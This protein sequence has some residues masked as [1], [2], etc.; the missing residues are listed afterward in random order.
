MEHN[1]RMLTERIRLTAGAEP[2]L[3]TPVSG[4]LSTAEKYKVRINGTEWLAKFTKGTPLRV[5]WYQELMHRASGQMVNPKAFRLFE[6][7]TLCLLTRWIDGEGLDSR[8]R[9][10]G[11]EELR[12]YGRQAARILLDLH[13][14]PVRFPAY[15]PRLRER[16]ARAC[17]QARELDLQFPHRETCCEF[18]SREAE[19]LEISHLCLV[20]KDIRPENFIIRDEQLYL[21]DFDNGSLGER[22]TDF[23]YLT[24]MGGEEFFPFAGEVLA[25][26]LSQAEAEDFW[27]K[28]LFYSTLQVLEYGIWKYR[29]R[30]RQMRLQAEN[31]MLQYDDLSERIPLWLR[32]SS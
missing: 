5:Q 4:G 8:L 21:I 15:A 29:S 3:L 26:Y 31:L 6:D 19:R 14:I 1:T 22:A 32:G 28:N 20:H 17:A 30:G 24:T 12:S 7:G 27:E 10:A 9:S 25:A 23:S 2:E 16:T 13:E 18:L 11:P